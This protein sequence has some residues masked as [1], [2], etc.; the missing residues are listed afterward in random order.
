MPVYGFQLEI[1]GNSLKSIKSIE[2]E[3][4]TLNAKSKHLNSEMSGHFDRMGQKAKAFGMSV[5][6]LVF[7]G[8]GIGG[9]MG[10]GMFAKASL[11][12]FDKYEEGI[13]KLNAVLAST[14]G[15]AG[16]T[17]NELTDAAKTLSGQTLF[18]KAAIMDAQSMLLT[19]TSVRGEIFE[20]AMPAV[21]NF[22]TR[23]KMELP[24][25]ANM[26][27]KALNDPLKGMT[28]LQRQGVVFSDQQKETIRQFMA[29]GQVAKAQQ[30]ILTE[31]ETEFGGLAHAMTLTDAG[32]IKMAKKSLDDMKITIGEM[33]SKGLAGMSPILTKIADGFKDVFGSKMSD[34]LKESRLEMNAMFNVLK[35]GNLPLDQ[36]REL[37][38]KLNAS[39]GD[40]IGKQ[41]TDKTSLS[42]L[43]VLQTESNEKLLEKI[44]ITAQQEV[45]EKYFKQA[46]KAQDKMMEAQLKFDEMK[47][48]GYKKSNPL[49]I[50]LKQSLGVASSNERVQLAGQLFM[51][52]Q[53]EKY[54]QAMKMLGLAN[55]SFDKTSLVKT[56]ETEINKLKEKDKALTK[57]ISAGNAIKENAI[58][59]SALGGASGGLGEAKII[60]IDFHKALMEVNVPGGNGMDIVSKAPMSVEMMLRII[61]NL[62]QSQGST[63]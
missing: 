41:I 23:F 47:Q 35:E 49:L 30:V 56:G 14:R 12:A 48:E 28:R 37:I 25:A 62:S 6:N 20:K 60:K 1:S 33:L 58:N 3:L 43:N 29:I 50:A 44:K 17:I 10:G 11:E 40:Y 53:Q 38:D 59:T 42:E 18:G 61:N 13:A 39:Y 45:L 8:L 2:G 19:F 9:L 36:R 55:K 57:P 46:A 16:L 5:K 26:L 54:D 4:G 51:K 21:T 63:M 22:A 24:E 34:K 31:L 32:K 15:K 52:E 27:G 7:G